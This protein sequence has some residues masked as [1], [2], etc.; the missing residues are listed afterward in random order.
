MKTRHGFVSNSSATSFCIYGVEVEA[1]EVV[2][3]IHKQKEN[4]DKEK[5]VTYACDHEFNRKSYKFCPECG[6]SSKP[7]EIEDDDCGYEDVEEYF[8]ELDMDVRQDCEG[9]YWYI[10]CDV[11]RNFSAKEKVNMVAD[12]NK[13]LAKIFPNID[14]EFHLY[15]SEGG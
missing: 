7:I 5:E 8:A 13:K 14:P 10:G 9:E 4:N 1:G 2:A 11:T 15:S 12:F 3:L 6:A